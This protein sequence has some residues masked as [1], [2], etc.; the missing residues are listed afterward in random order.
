MAAGINAVTTVFPDALAGTHA[1]QIG[2]LSG[3]S[4]KVLLPAGIV[5]VA[6]LLAVFAL[7]GELEILGLGEMTARSLGLNVKL[8]R[9]LFL[10]LAAALAGAS[11][12]FAGLLS[13]IGLVVPHIVRM[14]VDGSR[15]L[16]L[17]VCALVGAAFLILCDTA[18]KTLF[19]PFELPVGIIVSFLGVPFFLWRMRKRYFLLLGLVCCFLAI[20]VMGLFVWDIDVY[21]SETV[22]KAR[23]LET[24]RGL[25][26]APGAFSFGVKSEALANDMLLQ[27]PELSW[28]AVNVRGSHADVLVRERVPKPRI[29]DETRPTMVYAAKSG[30]ITKMSVL[31]GAP[32]AAAGDTVEKGDVLVSGVMVSRTGGRRL[33]H[34]MAEVTARTW[35]E[36]SARTTLETAV[37]RYT[38]EVKERRALIIAGRRINLYFK[39]GILQSNY[40]KITLEKNVRL[41]GGVELPFAVVTERYEAYAPVKTFL[42]RDAAAE[43][44]KEGLMRRLNAELDGGEIASAA[45]EVTADGGAVTV[46]LRAEC[47][48]PIGAERDFTD[49]ETREYE[50]LRG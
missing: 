2:G 13:F 8:Y 48:E 40:D 33:V 17:A 34:A 19:A 23:I 36:L 30:V 3:V 47:L 10:V 28:F 14:L 24:L 25:G 1:F 27:I 49:A 29:V 37:K 18:A 21:G 6:S 38:G 32:A 35:Y 7:S 44:L 22:P 42:G 9:F 39:G 20:R 5:I 50:L 43:L 15:L 12:S 26:V 4:A 31:E 11:V 41:P 46:T 45:F 16:R